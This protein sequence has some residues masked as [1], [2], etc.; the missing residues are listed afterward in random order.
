MNFRPVDPL[1]IA[2]WLA[3]SAAITMLAGFSLL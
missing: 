1:A 3:I 2:A